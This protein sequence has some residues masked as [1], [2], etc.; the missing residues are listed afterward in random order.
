[1][2]KNWRQ[3]ERSDHPDSKAHTLNHS[4]ALNRLCL[5]QTSQAH[6]SQ[7]RGVFFPLNCSVYDCSQSHKSGNALLQNSGK[8]VPCRGVKC[9]WVK[10]HSA[11]HFE[12]KLENFVSKNR[13]DYHLIPKPEP[14]ISS[15]SSSWKWILP[16][17]PL[18]NGGS[19]GAA[20]LDSNAFRI[21][22]RDHRQLNEDMCKVVHAG[23]RNQMPTYKMRE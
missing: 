1:M 19:A 14:C 18:L 21:H 5:L 22:T 17:A 10:G 4:P 12:M 2:C 20:V 11:G 15:V 3:Y 16:K 6:C 23:D 13:T 8:L 9:C 7:D